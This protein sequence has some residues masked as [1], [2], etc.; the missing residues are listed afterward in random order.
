VTRQHTIV[1][2]RWDAAAAVLILGCFLTG[3]ALIGWAVRRG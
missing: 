1:V 2:T 3:A